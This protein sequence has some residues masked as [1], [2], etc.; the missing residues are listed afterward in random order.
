MYSFPEPHHS[1]Q[2]PLCQ[3][4]QLRVAL[5]DTHG[6]SYLLGNNHAPEVVNSSDNTRCFH[7]I[8]LRFNFYSINF[9]A[10]IVFHGDFGLYISLLKLFLTFFGNFRKITRD[11]LMS[12]K[13][14]LR[15]Y[16]LHRRRFVNVRFLI[17]HSAEES[18]FSQSAKI[19]STFS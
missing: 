4:Y 10:L 9:V 3:C 12:P 15:L 7:F 6:T 11:C 1:V 14:D 13:A 17:N 5:A 16:Y 2:K 18:C 19:S 8:F